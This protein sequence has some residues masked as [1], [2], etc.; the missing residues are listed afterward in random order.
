[1]DTILLLS[2]HVDS[3]RVVAP[4]KGGSR[5]VDLLA[6]FGHTYQSLTLPVYSQLTNPNF[7]LTVLHIMYIIRLPYITYCTPLDYQAK[8][9]SSNF[10]NLIYWLHNDRKKK[11]D[12]KTKQAFDHPMYTF[13]LL[14]VG[15]NDGGL[16]FTSLCVYLQKYCPVLG[17]SVIEHLN[18]LQRW[19]WSTQQRPLKHYMFTFCCY[20]LYI[21]YVCPLELHHQW[22]RRAKP[23]KCRLFASVLY[24]QCLI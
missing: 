13:T 4:D 19:L 14:L 17:V 1:M 5:S 16:A 18:A 15:W 24:M 2:K 10:V 22:K 3:R 6:S 11:R 12:R 9:L 23:G 7:T 21:C 8:S 20:I